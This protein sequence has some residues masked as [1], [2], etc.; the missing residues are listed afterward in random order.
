MP[1]N[2]VSG[3]CCCCPTVENEHFVLY[4]DGTIRARPRPD[5]AIGLKNDESHICLVEASS[6]RRFVFKQVLDGS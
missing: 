5:L 4:S 1:E 6:P 2:D 3:F